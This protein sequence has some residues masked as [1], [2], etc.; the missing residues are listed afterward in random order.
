MKNQNQMEVK[1]QKDL[2]SGFYTGYMGFSDKGSWFR[3]GRVQT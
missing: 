2:G 3:Y 1:I